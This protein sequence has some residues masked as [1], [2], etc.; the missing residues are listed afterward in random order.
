MLPIGDEGAPQPVDE[1]SPSLGTN[2]RERWVNCEGAHLITFCAVKC[3]DLIPNFVDDAFIRGD[4]AQN[5]RQSGDSIELDFITAIEG[6]KKFR[7]I[8]VLL[9]GPFLDHRHKG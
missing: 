3:L 6:P 9:G 5:N 2:S 8:V 4:V 7:S 1:I